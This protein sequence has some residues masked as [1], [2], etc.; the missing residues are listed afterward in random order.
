MANR[1]YKIADDDAETLLPAPNMVMVNGE[2]VRDPSEDIQL[3]F[4]FRP[5]ADVVAPEVPDG[6]TLKIKYEYR[7]SDGKVVE[8]SRKAKEIYPIYEVITPPP[9]PPRVFSKINLE[10]AVFK[11]GRLANLDAFVDAQTISNELGDTMPLR[12]AY[13]TAQTF[14][15]DHPLFASYL[16]AAKQALGVDGATAEAILSEAVEVE[17]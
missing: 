7:D 6:S 15:E 17:G 1:L 4:G 11:R 9:P 13:N 12:R 3:R 14:R 16:M 5:L 10:A 8:N 2:I